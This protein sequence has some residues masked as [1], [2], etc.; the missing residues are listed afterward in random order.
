MIICKLSQ[1][2][3]YDRALD[4][5]FTGLADGRIMKING[6]LDK[7]ELFTRLSSNAT[8]EKCIID[9]QFFI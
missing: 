6:N 3:V 8:A 9:F 1:A 2:F 7:I 4:A 5:F